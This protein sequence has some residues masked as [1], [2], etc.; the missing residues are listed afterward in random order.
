[1]KLDLACG[2]SKKEGFLGVDISAECKPDVVLDLLTF[3]WPWAD[4]SVDE[5]HCS[6]YIEHIPMKEAPDGRD[7]LIA[8]MDECWR[9]LK[10]GAIATFHCPCARSNR[11]FQDPTHRRFI[12]AET[13]LYF[14]RNWM[15]AN[16]L[17]HYGVRC[18]F[19]LAV[20]PVVPVEVQLLHPEAAMRRMNEG[21]NVVI[22]WRAIL[23]TR[24]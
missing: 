2:A 19:D 17:E 20:D 23:T 10:P 15:V 12:V 13:F 6:H 9:V 22:D 5:I 1:L 7:L 16:K 21:W 3:P 24:K 8:F 14:N 18:D 11:A 4:S